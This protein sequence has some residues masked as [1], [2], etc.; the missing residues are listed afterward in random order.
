MTEDKF[1]Y[2]YHPH[3]NAPKFRHLTYTSARE[4]AHRL[5]RENPGCEFLVLEAVYAA[6]RCDV[7]GRVLRPV[8]DGIPF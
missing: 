4:E 7:Q 2:V 5:A 6:I 1:W 3:G 8:D